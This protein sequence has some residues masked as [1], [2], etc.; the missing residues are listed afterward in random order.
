MGSRTDPAGVLRMRKL[1]TARRRVEETKGTVLEQQHPPFLAVFEKK[2]TVLEQ[3]SLPFL[4]V[5]PRLECAVESSVA[6]SVGPRSPPQPSRPPRCVCNSS[7]AVK[8]G[9]R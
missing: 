1:H 6:P 9:E 3:E 7:T 5:L 8:G 2:G 4:A